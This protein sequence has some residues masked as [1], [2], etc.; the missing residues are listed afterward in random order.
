MSVVTPGVAL[1]FL[2]AVL[3]GPSEML[4]IKPRL[5]A[6]K[7]S[8]PYVLLSSLQP[9]KIFFLIYMRRFNSWHYSLHFRE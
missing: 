2:L 1:K 3:Q 6:C 4:S 8:M 7:A 9:L 5:D